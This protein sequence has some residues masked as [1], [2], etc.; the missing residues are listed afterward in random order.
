M[1]AAGV[2]VTGLVAEACCLWGKV[3]GLPCRRCR[4][5][6]LTPAPLRT[7]PLALCSGFKSSFDYVWIGIF[8]CGIGCSALNIYAFIFF[9]SHMEAPK[10]P[11]V[12]SEEAYALQ[13]WSRSGINLEAVADALADGSKKPSPRNGKQANGA[14]N[15]AAN[16]AANGAASGAAAAKA[17]SL[18]PADLEAQVDKAVPTGASS[19]L[20]FQPMTLTFKDVRGQR[21]WC[22]RL[23]GSASLSVVPILVL[24]LFLQIRYSVPFPKDATRN[25]NNTG[26]A[27][28]PHANNL[29]LLK[30]ITGSFRPGVLTALMGASG[31][32]KT[33]RRAGS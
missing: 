5:H 27:D 20:P 19:A 7:P 14:A 24:S 23:A 8:V 30:G 21:P 13:H 4:R 6:A 28:G 15:G 31:A 26:S 22:R 3:S 17:P 32:G 2:A 1:A 16:V 10:D 25:E 29:I 18:L 12:V 9:L 33:V 11:V